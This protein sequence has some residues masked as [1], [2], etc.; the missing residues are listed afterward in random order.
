MKALVYHGPRQLRWQDWPEPQPAPG[1][2]TIAVRAVGI[3]GSDLHGYQGRSSRRKAPMVMGHEFSGVVQAVGAD[4]DAQW[5]GRRVVIRPFLHCGAC[6]ACSAGRENLCRQRRYLGAT[7]DGAMAERIAVPLANLL[8]LDDRVSD[9]QAA[10]TE[11]LAVALHAARRCGPPGGRRVAVVGGGTIGLL[12]LAALRRFAAGHLALIESV[13]YRQQVGRSFGADRTL[14]AAPSG[15]EF[16]VAIDAV[17]SA[18]TFAICMDLVR[19]G[20]TLLALGGWTTVELDLG[21]LVAREIELKGSFNFTPDTFAEAL[22]WLQE[23]RVDTAALLT[24]GRPMADG[25]N[26]FDELSDQRIVDIKVML[27][28]EVPP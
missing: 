13:P 6:D 18:A 4:R 22:R 9:T 21:R 10:L 24:C 15:E 23:G 14:D 8:P 2:A 26:A 5:L 27:H 20:G 25:A 11:P 1:E 12:T 16:D 3:C 28:P 17:G 19:P 7:T